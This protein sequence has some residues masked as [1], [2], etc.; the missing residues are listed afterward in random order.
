MMSTVSSV[1]LPLDR[2]FQAWSHLNHD[3][4]AT[5]SMNGLTRDRN[6]NEIEQVNL[7]VTGKKMSKDYLS[8]VRSR[9]SAR[10]PSALMNY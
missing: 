4:Q 5:A 10:Q 7:E 6:V 3:Y 1:R 2:V 8:L 9:C